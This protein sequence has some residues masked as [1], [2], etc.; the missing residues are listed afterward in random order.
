[1]YTD[2]GSGVYGYRVRFIQI[3]GHICTDIGSDV[4]VQVEIRVCKH[5]MRRPSLWVSD[6]TP[7]RDTL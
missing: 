3:E 1:M 5:A 2:I 6:S 7:V 4:A